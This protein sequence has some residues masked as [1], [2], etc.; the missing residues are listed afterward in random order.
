M[1]V[2]PDHG[3]L[4]AHVAS[5][6]DAAVDDTLEAHRATVTVDSGEY[7][8]SLERS[9]ASAGNEASIGSRLPRARAMRYGAN[10][11]PRRGPH[12]GPVDTFDDGEVFLERMTDRLRR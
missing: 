7:A 4:L 8:A 5:S 3:P 1:I 11:G 2:T 10:V 12:H 9:R 6:F